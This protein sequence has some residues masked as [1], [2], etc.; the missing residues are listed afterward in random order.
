MQADLAHSLDL[1]FDSEKGFANHP[2][3]PGGPTQDGVTLRT[4]IAYRGH[5]VTVEELKQLSHEE[6]NAIFTEQYAEPVN[7]D[8]LP[9]GVDYCVLDASVNS[10]PNRAGRILQAALGM[11]GRDLDGVIGK[12][13]LA[14]IHNEEPDDLIYKYCNARLAFMK[15][16]KNWGSF[17]KG[18]SNRVDTVKSEAVAMAVGRT[19]GIAARMPIPE[20]GRAKATGPTKLIQLPSGQAAIATAGSVALSAGTMATQATGFLSPYADVNLIRE[21]LIGLA[22]ISSVAGVIV[23]ATRAQ[24]GA[25]T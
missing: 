24:N 20:L 14:E 17:G 13:T 25:T 21:G 4:L 16:L 7:F 10:G 2:K 6:R 19:Y 22:L 12:H 5:S 8:D 15:S 18:W 9:A 3:D 1:I 23:A 11:K